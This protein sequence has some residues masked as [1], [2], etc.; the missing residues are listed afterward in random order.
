MCSVEGKPGTGSK[1]VQVL[2][3]ARSTAEEMVRPSATF[4]FAP[5]AEMSFHR[6]RR[7]VRQSHKSLND[8]EVAPFL[9]MTIVLIACTTAALRLQRFSRKSDL[10]AA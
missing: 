3:A 6:A 8:L 9:I 4:V 5:R 1:L 10:C 2:A 7:S